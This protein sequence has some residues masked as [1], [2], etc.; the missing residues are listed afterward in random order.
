[1]GDVQMAF[2]ILTRCFMQHPLY[3]LQCTFPSFTF[4]KSFISF[5]SSF[6]Q[7]FGHLLGLGSFD[8]LE[9]PLARKQTSFTSRKTPFLDLF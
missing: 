6:L 5:D 7:L 1:M 9:R 3:L 8:S 4:T 2:G